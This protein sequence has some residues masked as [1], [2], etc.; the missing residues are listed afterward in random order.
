MEGEIRE[1]NK[2]A[3]DVMTSLL[4]DPTA[5]WLLWLAKISPVL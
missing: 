1:I 3:N 5:G 2:K 4:K